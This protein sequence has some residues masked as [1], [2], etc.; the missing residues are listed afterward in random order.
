MLGPKAKTNTR[1]SVSAFELF[2]LQEE[3]RYRKAKFRSR[4]VHRGVLGEMTAHVLGSLLPQQHKALKG[5]LIQ[6]G[7]IL[8]SQRCLLNW[9]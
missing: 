6:Q 5:C 2:R 7:H 4:Y 8:G 9:I 3:C 1:L